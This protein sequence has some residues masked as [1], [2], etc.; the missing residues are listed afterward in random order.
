MRQFVAEKFVKETIFVEIPTFYKS[1]DL[2]RTDFFAILEDTVVKI[3]GNQ[4]NSEYPGALLKIHELE[5]ISKSEFLEVWNKCLE[6]Q[7]KIISELI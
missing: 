4:I 7:K 1:Q 6:A 2:E 3:T 5:K